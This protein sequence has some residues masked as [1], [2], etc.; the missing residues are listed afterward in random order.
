MM[1]DNNSQFDETIRK[2]EQQ[3]EQL[4]KVLYA[5][6]KLE[7]IIPINL[8]SNLQTLK[9][10]FPDLYKKFASYKLKNNYKL[11]CNENGE[12]NILLPNGN[13]F[14]GE[15][16]F[17]DC[18]KQVNEFLKN[19]SDHLTHKLNCG[20]E[21][22]PYNQLHFYYKNRVY[23]QT[24]KILE[25]YSHDSSKG[26]KLESIPLMIMY[27]LG[28]GYHL[29]YLYEQ[30]TPLNLYIIE[31]NEDF[32]YLSLC[33]FDYSSLFEYICER[34]LGLKFVFS[35][36]PNQVIADINSYSTKYSMNLAR[37]SFFVHY[38]S[39]PLR[40][41]SSRIFNEV[42]SFTVKAGFFD[43]ILIGMCQSRRNILNGIKILS[44]KKLSDKFNSIPVLVVG[45]GPSLDND[46][47]LIKK[48]NNKVCILACGTALTSLTN[49]GIKVDIAVEVERVPEVYESLLTIKD[50]SIFDN[51]LFIGPDIVHSNVLNIYKHKIIGLKDN[52]VIGKAIYLLKHETNIN[53]CAALNHINPLVSNMGLEIASLLGFKDIYLVGVDNGSAYK[54]AHSVFSYYYDDEQQ[55]KPKYQNMVLNN[56]PFTHPGNFRPEIRTNGE[57]KISI[58][59]M[60]LVI[61]ENKDTHYYNASDGAK[62][63]G[64]ISKHLYD[65]NWNIYN[66]FDH[67]ELR[68][69]VITNMTD[70]LNVTN[71]DFTDMLNC[72]RYYEVIDILIEDLK[73]LPTNREEIVLRL[74]VHMDFIMDLFRE[75][76]VACRSVLFGSLQLLYAGYLIA[77]YSVA[78]QNEAIKEC[79]PIID[80]IIEFLYKTKIHYSH[81]FEFDYEYINE[82]IKPEEEREEERLRDL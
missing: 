70:Q 58:Q 74:E 68:D 27:G 43:D 2:L 78:D 79:K 16:P 21:N 80:L 75:G 7:E 42:P 10:H 30:F 19:Q 15:S 8:N 52:E 14:Y 32:F 77:L 63:S 3:K 12:G 51:I 81:A 39:D 35:E 29:S 22:N 49:Y 59:V 9:K 69:Y 25:K 60:E 34:N 44:N 17:D 33:V 18:K 38:S 4:E 54:E 64:T 6:K 37:K 36:D 20:Q 24:T 23:A 71:E 45:N 28:L 66:E 73:K 46:L 57:F 62:I 5:Q 41:I 67:N 31:P 13:L 76:N 82:H 40:N 65:V 50:K 47:E 26:E 53:N 61:N 11:T 72:Q 48:I 56:L 55:L 1:L